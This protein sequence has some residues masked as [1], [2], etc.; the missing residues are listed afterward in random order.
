MKSKLTFVWT[1]FISALAIVVFTAS[2]GRFTSGIAV[3]IRQD[4]VTDP[5]GCTS[6]CHKAVAGGN[7]PTPRLIDFP[8]TII[9]GQ[10]YMITMETDFD[11]SKTL[12]NK[13]SLFPAMQLVV[14]SQDSTRDL[15]EFECLDKVGTY[16]ANNYL[17]RELDKVLLYLV[18]G[19]RGI[20][21]FTTTVKWTASN[22]LP[23]GL[24]VTGRVGAMYKSVPGAISN[25]S[26]GS[27]CVDTTWGCANEITKMGTVVMSNTNC[28]TQTDIT[29]TNPIPLP[30]IPAGST[31]WFEVDAKNSGGVASTKPY[32]IGCYLSSDNQLNCN[33]QFIGDIGQPDLPKTGRNRIEGAFTMPNKPAG[34]YFLLLLADKN[35]EIA[36]CNEANN[37]LAIPFTITAGNGFCASKSIYNT[38]EFI[39]SVK[40]GSIE[41]S[42]IAGFY[43]EK[44]YLDRHFK[45]GLAQPVTITGG[46]SGPFTAQEHC[47]IWADLNQDNQFAS[48]EIVFSKKLTKPIAASATASISGTLTLPLSAKSGYTRLRVSMQRGSWPPACGN[49]GLGEVE[50]YVVK[51]VDELHPGDR[52]TEEVFAENTPDFSLAPNPATD[53]TTVDLSAF[54][55]KEIDVATFD[56][57]GKLVFQQKMEAAANPYLPIE[58]G[59]WEAGIYVVYVR[60]EGFRP[61]A[62]KL[63][64]VRM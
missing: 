38:N 19:K 26:G 27:S 63:A 56:L 8:T 28:S 13:D 20:L 5:K 3:D 52:Q 35:S 43:S 46:F 24:I 9:P 60:A 54:F 53:G 39:K 48:D 57:K 41:S 12:I 10:P 6:G 29:L 45:K 61:V 25:C 33:D 42:S 14:F 34:N 44:L 30:P 4:V 23:E 37:T 7:L 55:G 15:G 59:N 17:Y 31:T 36:E 22:D 18:R 50:D 1:I 64:V 2:T 51:V 11:I 58:T 47:R 49:V 32:S 21:K 40:I 62:R 16:A